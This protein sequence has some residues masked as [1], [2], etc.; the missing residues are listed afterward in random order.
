MDTPI[1]KPGDKVLVV[2][3]NDRYQ[4]DPSEIPDRLR[5]EF[6]ELEIVT[7]A[8]DNLAPQV[9]WVFRRD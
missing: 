7:Y 6:P 9:L 5:E 8:A 2:L 3:P 1:V 4:L